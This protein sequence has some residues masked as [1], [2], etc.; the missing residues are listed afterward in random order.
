QQW[1]DIMRRAVFMRNA[2]AD[3]NGSSFMTERGDGCFASRE[4][5]QQRLKARRAQQS[6]WRDGD[7]GGDEGEI[8]A[9]LV[10]R[11]KRISIKR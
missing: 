2:Q 7:T 4:K 10:H 8:I 5:A 9:Q 6:L 11:L 3:G 1:Q